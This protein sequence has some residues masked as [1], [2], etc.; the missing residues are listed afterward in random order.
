MIA[1]T[2]RGATNAD[3]A[4]AYVQY[5]LDTG[6]AEFRQT[7]GNRG[8]LAFRRINGDRA[9]FVVLSF[10]ESEAA[11]RRFAGDD[12]EKAVFYPEDERFLVDRDTRVTHYEV[13]F[14]SAAIPQT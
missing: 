7:E 3:D 6:L 5:L 13:V 11:V 12:I 2:W 14:D 4:E 8:A 9:E 1:R 10:W